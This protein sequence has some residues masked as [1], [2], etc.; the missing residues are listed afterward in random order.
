MGLCFP[1]EENVF[2]AGEQPAVTFSLDLPKVTTKQGK[3]WTRD[4]G[5]Y[6][7]KQLKRQAV[8]VSEEEV[9]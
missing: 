4:M 7:V 2:W 8:E 9:E 6:F 3:E 5:C 1:E